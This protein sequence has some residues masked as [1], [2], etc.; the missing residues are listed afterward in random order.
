MHT[1]PHT[2]QKGW[3]REFIEEIRYDG[4]LVTGRRAG[5]KGA[6]LYALFE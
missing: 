3:F 6:P 4:V 5:Y 2:D 1:D